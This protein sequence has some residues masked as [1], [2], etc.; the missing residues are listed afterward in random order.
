[1]STAP[2]NQNWWESIVAYGDWVLGGPP[3]KARAAKKTDAEHAA[4]AGEH[5]NTRTSTNS[6]GGRP[7][8]AASPASRAP[9]ESPRAVPSNVETRVDEHT[10]TG[11]ALEIG[12]RDLVDHIAPGGMQIYPDCIEIVGEAWVRV[13]FVEDVPPVMGRAQLE[14]LYNFPAEIRHSLQILPL[15]K[16]AVREQLRQRRTSLH[17]EMLTRQKQGRLADYNAQDEL[18]ETER[19][20]YELESTHLPPQEL[21]WTIALYASNRAEL[22]NLSRKL[23]DYLLDGDM[24]AHRASLRQEEALHSTQPFGVN[25]IGH[26]RNINT[27]A[28]AGMFPFSRRLRSDPRGIP[29]GIDRS[30]GAWV[31]ID[32]FNLTNSNLLIVGE[33]GSGKSMFL[34]YKTMWAILLGM[35]VYILDLEGEFESMCRALGGSYLDMALTSPHHMN[36]LDLNPEDPD[37]WTNGMQDA[38]AWLSIGLGAGKNQ[39]TPRERNVILIPAY[40]RVMEAAGIYQDQPETWRRRAPLLNDLY[41]ALRSDQRRDATDIADRLETMAAGVYAKAFSSPTNINANAS[42]VVFGLKNV[43]A[44]MQ[45]LRMRQIQTFIWSNVLSKMQP[46]LVVV[47]EAW[48]WLIHEKASEDL[49]EMARRFR[50]RYAG[51]SLATQHGIDFSRS[52][53][54]TVIRDTAAITMLFRQNSPAVPGLQSLFG[55]D[56]LESRELLT[57]DHGESILLVDG[58]RFPIYT[59]IP[60]AWYSYWTTR[61]ADMPQMKEMQ[62]A[63]RTAERAAPSQAQT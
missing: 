16:S 37:A 9:R 61:P 50:K 1:M 58:N 35:R 38:M 47:D 40:Q 31:I 30:T 25:F 24:K 45:A 11:A 6:G 29:Y 2:S 20:L 26:G 59:A 15:D 17:A 44:E 42:L 12:I 23:E 60:P 63:V 13:W 41:M 18:G 51:L 28:L 43:H 8:R 36:V 39:L 5:Q 52:G 54:A 34:K 21:L 55:L 53:E 46:T 10:A 32:D 27:N 19:T 4:P 56:E 22:D 33:Q 49:A 7:P 48:R 57:L 14:S 3:P 62:N